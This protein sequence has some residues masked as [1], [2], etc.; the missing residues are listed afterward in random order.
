MIWTKRSIKSIWKAEDTESG[1]RNN[2][3]PEP[4]LN[5]KT[6]SE[7]SDSPKVLFLFSHDLFGRLE[8]D[9]LELFFI[10]H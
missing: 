4:P 5:S 8:D 3:D 6:L 9:S 2:L 10:I 7:S 1:P